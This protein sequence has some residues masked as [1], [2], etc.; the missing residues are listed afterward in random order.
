VTAQPKGYKRSWKNLLLNKRY[1][2]RFTLFM[3]GISALLMAGLGIWVMK[4]A[5][6][7]TTVAIDR[8]RGDACPKIPELTDI[9]TNDDSGVPLKLPDGDGSDAVGSA[10]HAPVPSTVDPKDVAKHTAQTDLLS[11]KALWCTTADCAP[12]AAEP[13]QI[14]V[15][16]CDAYVKAKLGDPDAV[17]A[18]RK[19]MI[20]VVKC[21]GGQAFSV[22]DAPEPRHVTVQLD[23]SSMTMTPAV[24]GDYADRVVAHW[25]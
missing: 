16:D 2:L 24:P 20:P 25:T 3:V 10:A 4:Q 14:K 11:V 15:K 13:L 21:D 22:A 8:V 23:E 18:L 1:Q 7:A 17:A 9:P 12:A 19:A 5:N 6:E